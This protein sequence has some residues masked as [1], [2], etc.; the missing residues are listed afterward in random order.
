MNE[1]LNYIFTSKDQIITLL[2]EHIKLT[3]LSVGIAIII[4]MPLG[5]LTSYVKKLN[6][7]ILGIAS[8][9]QAIPSMA[10]LGFAIPFLGIGTPPAIVMVVLYSLLPIIKNTTTGIDSINSDMLEASK[11]IGLT[12]FQVLVKVQIPLALPV[13]MSG[14]RISAVTAVGLM[15]MAAFIGGG[16]LGYL[17]FSGIRTVNNYQILAGAIPAC[18]LA[19]LVDGLFSIVEKLVTP[20]SLQKANNKSKVAKIRARKIQKGILAATAC[21]LIG[22]FAVSGLS[23]KISN[24]KVITIGS[25]DFTEQEVLGNILSELIER[26]TDI[27]VNRKFALGGTQVIFSAMQNG[28]VDMSVD[29]TGTAYGDELK[30]KPISDVEEVYNT[31][32]KDF[33]DKYNIEVLKQMG[34]NNT[35]TLAVTKETAK[36]Y[37]LKTI[38][39]LSKVSNDI[40]A[41]T[42]LEFLNREDGLVGLAKKYNLNFKNTVGIDGS[43]RYAALMNKESD[44][45]DAFSTDGLLKKYD[46]SVLKDDKNFF[47]PYYAVPVV[48][49]ETLKKYPEIQP[50]VEGVGDLLNNDV[51]SELN[52]EVDELKKDPKDVAVDFLEKNGLI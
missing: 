17:V 51:M 40:T 49:A 28:D 19:L 37:N 35:Y 25:K 2:L 48:R 27:S 30:Y 6:K 8:V 29:Y 45:I 22:I 10:L 47:P 31:V 46:L 34:F 9:V 23:K 26:K 42:T 43:P 21:V 3:A 50:L 4:G 52:Y 33:K 36:K 41:T 15:T 16:G 32:K 1:F 12:K 20:I 14:I 38:S 13:I 11:G 24:K 39:D 7:P 44:V 5:I 18:I